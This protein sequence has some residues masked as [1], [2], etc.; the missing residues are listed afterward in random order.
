MSESF[1]PKKAVALRYDVNQD[2]APKVSATGKGHVA[3]KILEK[4][5][6]SNVPI[7]EDPNMI[8]LLSELNINEKI[9]EDLYQA[10][11]EV[12]AYIYQVDKTFDS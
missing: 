11:A 1:K 2:F 8:E 3:E 12:F 7:Q 10:V 5:K 6:Q 9:P 4:A